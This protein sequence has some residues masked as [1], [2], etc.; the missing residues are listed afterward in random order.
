MFS[1]PLSLPSGQG[2]GLHL[3]IYRTSGRKITLEEDQFMKGTAGTRQIPVTGHEV[4]QLRLHPGGL[5]ESTEGEVGPKRSL[6][7]L[8]AEGCQPALKAIPKS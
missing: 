5:P 4:I 8:D 6:L 3:R 7:T 2:K 1:C